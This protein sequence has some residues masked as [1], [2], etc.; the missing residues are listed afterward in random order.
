MDVPNYSNLNAEL[1]AT[2]IG[3]KPK[4]IPMLVGSFVDESHTILSALKAAIDAMDFDANQMQAH[5]I[6]GSSGNLK[7]D[8]LY[9]ISKTME[10]AA[11]EKDLTYAYGEVFKVIS[12]S[13]ASISLA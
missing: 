3:L 4:H 12:E 7:F 10:F 1:M 2:K 5:S 11:K 13:V 6:K 8:E 9:E